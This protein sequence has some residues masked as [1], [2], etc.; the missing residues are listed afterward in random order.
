M[1][2]TSFKISQPIIGRS[3][4]G[5]RGKAGNSC[6]LKSVHMYLLPNSY[7]ADLGNPL[8]Q[9][10]MNPM[11]QYYLEHNHLSKEM[12]WDCTVHSMSFLQ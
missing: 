6:H 12:N 7:S 5:S 1:S 10:R 8:E 9:N 3:P 4:R 2:N 11:G